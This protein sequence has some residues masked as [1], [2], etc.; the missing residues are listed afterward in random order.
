M[1]RV[2]TGCLDFRR[3]RSTLELCLVFV[4]FG[5]PARALPL[6]EII[7]RTQPAV[8]HVS[9]SDS[10]GREFA[11]G[12]GFLVASDGSVATN[13]HVV[14]GADRVVVSFQG[15]RKVE[16]VG[17]V[18][19]D[20]EADL[21]VL[22]LGPG[23]YPELALATSPAK[24]GDTVVVIGSPMGFS[25]S[26]STGIVSAI[27]PEG[28]HVRDEHFPNW[29]LQLTAAVSPGSSGSPVVNEQGEVV[30]VAV[31]HAGGEALNFGVPVASLKKVMAKSKP[32][33]MPLQALHGGRSPLVNVLISLGAIGGAAAAVWGASFIR[34]R[35]QRKRRAPG[36]DVLNSILKR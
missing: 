25:G 10:R 17:V 6:S 22:K 24:Q 11:T 31:G 29:T 8:V 30:A 2:K 5:A 20:E 1:A 23:S 4:A 33:A 7:T 36:R 34:G 19:F 9:V 16:A 27:R 12:S 32:V 21:A 28:A 15:G 26:V 35:K 13:H 3:I 14:E 18:A